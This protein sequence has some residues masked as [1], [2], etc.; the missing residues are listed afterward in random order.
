MNKEEYKLFMMMN[1]K[2]KIKQT[3]KNEGNQEIYLRES[4]NSEREE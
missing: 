3:A 2:K 1:K 4:I